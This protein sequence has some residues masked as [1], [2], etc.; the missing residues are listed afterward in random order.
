M[1]FHLKI[2]K[3]LTKMMQIQ[4]LQWQFQISIKCQLYLCHHHF[5]NL[6]LQ[7]TLLKDFQHFIYHILVVKQLYLFLKKRRGNQ[8]IIL[9]LYRVGSTQ[10]FQFLLGYFLGNSMLYGFSL[11]IRY[12]FF[13]WLIVDFSGKISSRNR[14]E[15]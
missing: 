2:Q 8:K 3:L 1:Q 4:D 12:I 15:I 7:S 13:H 14:Q 5:P 11:I 6:Q 10:W 9:N